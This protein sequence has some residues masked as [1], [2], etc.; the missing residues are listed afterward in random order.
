MARTVECLVRSRDRLGEVP[1]WCPRTDRLW[2]VDVREPCLQ[3][4]DP[5]TGQHEIV[6]VPAPGARLGSWGFRE[7]GGFVLGMNDG[8]FGFEAGSPT[9][10]LLVPLEADRPENRLN[11]AKVD[12]RGRYWVGTMNEV[13]GA[14]DGAF[15][16][17]W[18][19][20]SVVRL[21]GEVQVPNAIAI[22]PDD[23]TLYFGDTRRCS[24]WAFDFEI[25][26]GAIGNRRLFADRTAE[27]I[28]PDG[29]CVDSDGGLWSTEYLNSRVVRYAPDG[30]IDETIELPVSQ[31]TSCGFGGPGLQTL[32]I[33]TATQHMTAEQRDAE[34]LAGSL[35]AVNVGR[36]GAPEP[37]FKG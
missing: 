19:D 21:F 26:S 34:P 12:R 6:P 13:T 5:A 35:F 20:L 4:F 29:A 8:F 37:A 18:P 9:R 36:T 16:C 7:S 31:I 22:A 24:I 32:F 33:T 2:W 1:L 27:G 10:E 25:E 11:D 17:I 14:A 3:S 23:R 30:H 28:R 15:Y